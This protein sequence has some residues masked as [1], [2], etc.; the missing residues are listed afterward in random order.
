MD[1]K[2]ERNNDH[3]KLCKWRPVEDDFWKYLGKKTGRPD[4]VTPVAVGEGSWDS[5]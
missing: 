5:R 1:L 3:K 2:R 4:E